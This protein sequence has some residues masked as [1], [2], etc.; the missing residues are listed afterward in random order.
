MDC[1]SGEEAGA[2]RTLRL[3]LAL[4]RIIV[5]CSVAR[6]SLYEHGV[7]KRDLFRCW[8]AEVTFAVVSCGR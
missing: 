7:T 3:R 8:L 2:L 1:A 5:S 4:P 6:E